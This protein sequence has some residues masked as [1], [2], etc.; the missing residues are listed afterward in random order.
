MCIRD[1]VGREF[2]PA[3]TKGAPKVAVINLTAAKRFFG[4]AQNALGRL[5]A[6]GGGDSIKLDTT[7]VGVVGDV[8]HQDLRTDLSLIHI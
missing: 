8:K 5:I 6:E 1:S 4:S 2:T 7:V 3:D